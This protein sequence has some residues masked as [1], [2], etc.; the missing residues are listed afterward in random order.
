LNI[1]VCI[2]QVP[3]INE[4]KLNDE[5]NTLIRDKNNMIINPV[6]MY[7]IEE[8]IKIK[9]KRDSPDKLDTKL[10][11]F[12]LIFEVFRGH[13]VNSRMTTVPIVINLNKLKDFTFSLSS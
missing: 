3:E 1:I 6:D 12:S 8:C 5:N 4:V 2:K 13:T 10:S 11:T 9:E 7:A